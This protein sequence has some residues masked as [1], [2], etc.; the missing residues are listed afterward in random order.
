MQ[1]ISMRLS[2]RTWHTLRWMFVDAITVIG[3]YSLVFAARATMVSLV[4]RQSLV[5]IILAA[6]LMVVTLYL[7]GVYRRIWPRTSGHEVSVI[8][9]S[10][11]FATVLIVLLNLLNT[12]RPLP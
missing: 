4:Y 5:Y 1:K 10:V 12:P 11:M 6:Q 2:K 3:A 7:F 8:I 9:K